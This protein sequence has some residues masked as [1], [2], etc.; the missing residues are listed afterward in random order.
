MALCK[1]KTEVQIYAN[2]FTLK[3]IFAGSHEHQVERAIGH[4]EGGQPG[5]EVVADEHAEED[6]IVDDALVRV[7]LAAGVEGVSV[8]QH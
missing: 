7:A 1:I 3:N 4:V 2:M 5:D 6:E 8:A